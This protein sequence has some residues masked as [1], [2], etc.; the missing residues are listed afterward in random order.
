MPYKSLAKRMFFDNYVKLLEHKF[1]LHITPYL[2]RSLEFD[3]FT[4]HFQRRLKKRG[5]SVFFSQLTFSLPFAQSALV[6][7][8]PWG[9]GETGTFHSTLKFHLNIQSINAFGY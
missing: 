9:G 5:I 4:T 1:H 3:V 8:Y 7:F 6:F 2:T